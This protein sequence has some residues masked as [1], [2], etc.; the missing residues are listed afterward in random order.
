[1]SGREGVVTKSS[2]IYLGDVSTSLLSGKKSIPEGDSEVKLDSDTHKPLLVLSDELT[3]KPNLHTTSVL[4]CLERAG[5]FCRQEN[6]GRRVHE[7]SPSS[8]PTGCTAAS[9]TWVS[10][11]AMKGDTDLISEYVSYLSALNGLLDECLSLSVYC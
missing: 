7:L 6:S 5:R 8:E 10:S 11:I 3:P 1:M 4:T 2:V 9:G